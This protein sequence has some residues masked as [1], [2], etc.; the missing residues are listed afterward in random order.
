[1]GH[2]VSLRPHI[3]PENDLTSCSSWTSAHGF[4]FVS[5]CSSYWCILWYSLAMPWC[6]QSFPNC[7]RM[8]PKAS[9]L[10]WAQTEQCYDTEIYFHTWH[11]TLF[12]SLGDGSINIWDYDFIIPVPQINGGFSAAGALVLSGHAEHDAVGPFPQIQPL[13][14]HTQH[15]M[16]KQNATQMT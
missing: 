2:Q 4:R 15:K 13:L 12:C 7:G 3:C 11:Q 16:H 8:W 10:A 5:V 14:L 1:M 6:V 9:D